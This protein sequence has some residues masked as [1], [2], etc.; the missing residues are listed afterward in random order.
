MKTI[1]AYQCADGQIFEDDRKAKAHDDDLLGQELDGLLKLF[2]FDSLT[3]NQEYRSLIQLMN[4]RKELRTSMD[5]ISRL[6]EH[7]QDHT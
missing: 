6:L 4:N 2:K 5:T 3:R 7:G 1:E